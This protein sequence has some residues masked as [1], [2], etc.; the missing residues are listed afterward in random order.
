[1]ELR[2]RLLFMIE[3]TLDA[4][5]VNEATPAGVRKIVAVN[6]GTFAGPRLKGVILP[7]GAADWALTRN[8]GSL[9]LDVRL[10]L[11]TEDSARIFMTYRGVRHGPKEVLERLARGEAVDPSEYYFRI[12]PFFE[13][14][15]ARY[16]WLNNIVCVGMG[17]RLTRGP[18]YTV[19]EIL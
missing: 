11:E 3:P 5:Q 6:G 15:A 10:T 1:M 17:E 7:A 4:P 2:S 18:R 13:T 9:L 16:T 12:A 8:D 14:G 19:F